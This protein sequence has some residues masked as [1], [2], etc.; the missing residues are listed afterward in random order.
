[1]LCKALSLLHMQLVSIYICY[2][3]ACCEFHNG[4]VG[5]IIAMIINEV[6]LNFLI[7]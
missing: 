3:V 1:M 5:I 7:F 6:S 2:D 4:V